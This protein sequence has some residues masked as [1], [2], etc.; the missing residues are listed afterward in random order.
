M[1]GVKFSHRPPRFRRSAG[2]TR[3]RSLRWP[4]GQARRAR[5]TLLKVAGVRLRRARRRLIEGLVAARCARRR[6]DGLDLACKP[7]S[8][9]HRRMVGGCRLSAGYKRLVPVNRRLRY[10]EKSRRTKT[11]LRFYNLAIAAPSEGRAAGLER[12]ERQKEKMEAALRRGRASCLASGFA[13]SGE[14]QGWRRCAW[15]RRPSA[16]CSRSALEVVPL[17]QIKQAPP[18]E[19]VCLLGQIARPLR[20]ASVELFHDATPATSLK[21]NVSARALRVK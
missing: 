16:T 3:L 14:E 1:H 9:C 8:A 5:E 12:W 6:S 17:G 20:E 21:V 18:G 11:S 19:R 10:R 2:R 7:G 15:R 13:G 4:F